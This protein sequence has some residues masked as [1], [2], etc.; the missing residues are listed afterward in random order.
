MKN[1]I[2]IILNIEIHLL[3]NIN[4]IFFKNLIINYIE[5]E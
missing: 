2:E 3:H 1:N 5:I 4:L